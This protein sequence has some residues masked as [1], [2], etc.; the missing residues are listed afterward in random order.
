RIP[1]IAIGS[2]VDLGQRL[3]N[4]RWISLNVPLEQRPQCRDFVGSDP[5]PEQRAV[6]A[7]LGANH[8]QP[9]E[10]LNRLRRDRPEAPPVVDEEPLCPLGLV[11]LSS[12]E[13]P[14]VSSGGIDRR[15]TF[16]LRAMRS[17]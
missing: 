7:R 1:R 13:Q 5:S 12:S 8:V 9:A 2:R 10:L 3:L 15:M 17:N 14:T 6:N 16:E 11:Q 4:R